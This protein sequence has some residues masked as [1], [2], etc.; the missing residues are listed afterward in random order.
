MQF[1]GYSGAE[2]NQRMALKIG[3]EIVPDFMNNMQRKLLTGYM[4]PT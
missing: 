3:Q 2:G 1:A 4:K